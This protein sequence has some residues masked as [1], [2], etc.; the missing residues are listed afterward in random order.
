MDAEERR[1]AA[2][3]SPAGWH[4]LSWFAEFVASIPRYRHN[5][6][7][8]ARLAIA[9]R[10]HLFSWAQAEGIEFDL[11]KQGILHIYRDRK[12]FEHAGEVSKLLAEGGLERRAVTAAEMK[13][14]EPTLAGSYYGGYYTESDST[15]DIHKFTIGLAA[16]IERFGVRCIYGADVESVR[17]DGARVS[18]T[19]SRADAREDQQFD[20]VLVCAGIAS[21][22][23]ASQL[24]DRVSP[25]AHR[26]AETAK[27]HRG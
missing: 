12:G 11:R 2:G 19:F 15:G 4:K 6:V 27:A 23:L 13:Q 22:A 20:G 17:S 25:T 9:A 1:A 26:E 3:E 7:A 5:T 14:I 16:A 10:E 24:G 8:T 21:R 18:V